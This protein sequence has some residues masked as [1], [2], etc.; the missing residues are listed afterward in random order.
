M[1]YMD[2]CAAGHWDEMAE[3]TDCTEVG[4]FMERIESSGFVVINN[5]KYASTSYLR[6]DGL[7]EY[8]DPGCSEDR[9]EIAK[10]IEQ[11]ELGAYVEWDEK[12]PFINTNNKE[13]TMD[14]STTL[15]ELVAKFNASTDRIERGELMAQ[16][17]AIRP[18]QNSFSRKAVTDD[19]KVFNI[20][21][22]QW[23][24][25]VGKCEAP[26]SGTRTELAAAKNRC[27]QHQQ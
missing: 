24:K 15:E 23:I 20:R 16:I 17:K 7:F 8:L 21:C 26:I 27:E 11:V 9:K 19:G 6:F 2:Y 18:A 1:G 10:L 13:S 12:I 4:G 3:H 22:V 5:W 25:G 14:S